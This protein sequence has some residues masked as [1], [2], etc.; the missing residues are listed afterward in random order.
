MDLAQLYP[1]EP[2]RLAFEG[3]WETFLNAVRDE[4]DVFEKK[5]DTLAYLTER[6]SSPSIPDRKPVLLLLGNPATHSVRAGMFF[7]SERGGVSGYA[8]DT[9]RPGPEQAGRPAKA[10]KRGSHECGWTKRSGPHRRGGD[11]H[12]PA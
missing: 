12:R 8:E 5:G 4:G 10:R 1:N 2:D 11:P 3:R 6:L 9:G 7:G